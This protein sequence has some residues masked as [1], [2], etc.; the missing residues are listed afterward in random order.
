MT[1]LRSHWSCSI[2][3]RDRAA[4]ELWQELAFDSKSLVDLVHS[5]QKGLR[6]TIRNRFEEKSRTFLF[7]WQRF[8]Y[9]EE[10]IP[11]Y[12]ELLWR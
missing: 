11:V 2:R 6:D 8:P 7:Y 5:N 9:V 4:D 3:S 1:L 10:V 12:F